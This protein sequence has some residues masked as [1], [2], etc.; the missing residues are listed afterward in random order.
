[1]TDTFNL[2]KVKATMAIIMAIALFLFVSIVIYA[3]LSPTAVFSSQSSIDENFLV[4]NGSSI[5]FSRSVDSSLNVSVLNKTWLDF[6]GT[7]NNKQV[8]NLTNSI[9]PLVSNHT[10]TYSFWLRSEGNGTGDSGGTIYV[11]T[12]AL[13]TRN[14]FQ[15]TGSGWNGTDFN[16]SSAINN[17]NPSIS[18]GAGIFLTNQW[19][20]LAMS[21]YMLNST[22]S[23]VSAYKDGL[24]LG[25]GLFVDVSNASSLTVGGQSSQSVGGFFNGS[26]DEIRI[27]NRT[28]S[29]SE[30]SEIN[31][32]GIIAN[33]SLPSNQL[34]AWYSFNENTNSILYDKSPYGA[35]GTSQ[36]L[37]SLAPFGNDSVTLELSSNTDYN[38][39]N[40]SLTLKNAKWEFSQ[41]NTKYKTI[42]YRNDFDVISRNVSTGYVTFI[43]NVP[44][45]FII[46]AV[47]V[48]IMVLL[49]LVRIISPQGGSS[50]DGSPQL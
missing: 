18:I 19:Y 50:L 25:T 26:V 20:H 27:Y 41:L 34:I 31:S 29:S 37:L 1:M 47:T 15:L 17:G 5:T 13:N 48:I 2:E 11:L 33:S 8:A 49:V 10:F 38:N 9:L 4:H 40:V 44:T 24:L 43:G 36:A 28:L 46:L 32:S 39:S 7:S 22:T 23:N 21:V 42:N 12:S 35:N 30:I 16:A 6:D 3:Q 14:R 45:I